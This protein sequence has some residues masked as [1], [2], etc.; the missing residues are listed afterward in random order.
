MAPKANVKKSTGG[1]WVLRLR[2]AGDLTEDFVGMEWEAF[3]MIHRYHLARLNS[4][5]IK[6]FYT[7]YLKVSF[8]FLVICH[9]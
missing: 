6:N 5:G 3:R 9:K 2:E 7:F 4:I 1:D 8:F